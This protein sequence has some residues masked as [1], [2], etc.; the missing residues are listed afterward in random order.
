MRECLCEAILV[1]SDLL[2][3]YAGINIGPVHKRDIIVLLPC[4]NTYS[5]Y[6]I[7]LSSVIHISSVFQ[8]IIA[9]ISGSN[10][11]Q[12]LLYISADLLSNSKAPN[13]LAF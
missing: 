6:S 12:D 5:Q 13:F 7:L 8:I 11:F 9:F 1:S 10:V 3:Q 2:V 4:W